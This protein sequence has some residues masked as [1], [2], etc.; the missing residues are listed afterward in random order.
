MYI[1]AIAWIYVVLMM[2]ITEESIIAG[3]MT[4]ALY[5]ILPLTIIL[6]IMGSPQRKRQRQ[7]REAAARSEGSVAIADATDHPPTQCA[8]QTISTAEPGNDSLHG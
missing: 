6:Y 1:V 8:D 2:S 3:L 7:A 4:F 5:G